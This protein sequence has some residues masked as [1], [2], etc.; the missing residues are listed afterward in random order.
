MR[1]SPYYTP[2]HGRAKTTRLYHTQF[3]TAFLRE[4]VSTLEP[5]VA[6]LFSFEFKQKEVFLAQTL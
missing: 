3:Y 4:V 1:Q 5:V 2:V 6:N